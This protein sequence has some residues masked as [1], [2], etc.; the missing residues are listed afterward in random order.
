M[1]TEYRSPEGWT[2][3]IVPDIAAMSARAADR[4]EATL[5]DN[6]GAVISLPT[7]TTPLHLFDILAARVARGELDFSHADFYCLDDYLGL[8]GDDPHSLTHWLREALIARVNLAPSHVHEVPAAAPD[9]DVEAA[10]YDRDL[11]EH[12]GLD[13]AVVGIGPNGHVAFNEPGAESTSRTRVVD[14]KP[15]TIAQATAYWQHAHAMPSKAMTIGIAN[16]LEAR[17]IVL[18]ASGAAK[19][20]AIQQALEGPIGPVLPASF[21][22]RAGSRLEVILDEAA[23]ADL[24]VFPTAGIRERNGGESHGRATGVAATPA[25]PSL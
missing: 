3:A 2:L 8:R 12:G 16:L 17:Q 10:N 4:V 18:I 22:R 20:R 9:P 13:L 5:R 11:A 1:S 24:T 15:E 14:L 21:L 7:G 19:A 25:D 23:A 6:P